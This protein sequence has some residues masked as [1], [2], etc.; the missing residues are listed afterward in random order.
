[1][2]ETTRRDV[3]VFL[4]SGSN[5][6]WCRT[7]TSLLM[8]FGLRLLRLETLHIQV[9]AR[10][11]QP[12]LHG[13]PAAPFATAWLAASERAPSVAAIRD[14]IGQFGQAEAVVV[15]LPVSA[16][17]RAWIAD[18]GFRVLL[19]MSTR[20]TDVERTACDFHAIASAFVPSGGVM[21]WIIPVGWPSAML[22][23]DYRPILDRAVTGSEF[24]APPSDRVILAGRIPRFDFSSAPPIVD[25][26]ISLA[27]QDATATESIAYAMLKATGSSLLEDPDHAS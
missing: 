22:G 10:G 23:S 6:Q 19:P 25:G 24:P 7:T 8:A 27:P 18:P 11:K 15:D 9:T 1:M 21:P 20:P 13:E 14:C 4:V 2:N 26:R 5:T 3:E 16:F 17:E 12:I